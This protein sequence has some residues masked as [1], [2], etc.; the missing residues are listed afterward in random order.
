MTR[1]RIGSALTG[2]LLLAGCDTGSTT[3]TT[4][5]QGTNSSTTS[6]GTG[7]TGATAAGPRV[8]DA[9]LGTWTVLSGQYQGDTVRIVADSLIWGTAPRINMVTSLYP[10][11]L[12]RFYA[13]SGTMGVADGGKTTTD[14]AKYEY[15]KTGDTLWLEIQTGANGG[16]GVDRTSLYC[17][18][19]LPLP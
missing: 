14:T 1:R 4:A 7:G 8:E 2:V 17:W 19:L 16:Y 11:G 12:L 10:R 6:T 18:P 13:N 15:L 5:S 9:V 3:A